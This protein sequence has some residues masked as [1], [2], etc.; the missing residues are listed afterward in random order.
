MHWCTVN[1]GYFKRVSKSKNKFRIFKQKTN[2]VK[3]IYPETDTSN[4]KQE[5]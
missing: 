1:G 5:L 2:F 4:E 3:I